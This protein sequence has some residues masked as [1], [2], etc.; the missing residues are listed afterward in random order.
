M[1]ESD[2]VLVFS[3]N[4]D[5]RSIYDS[6]GR[7]ENYMVQF[8]EKDTSSFNI[9]MLQ[10]FKVIII[11]IM[12]PSMTEIEFIETIHKFEQE[13]PILVISSYFYE[14]KDI[15][16]GDKIAGFIHKPF[17]F[18]I[19]H[20][21]VN[22]ITKK[23]KGK[24]K[25]KEKPVVHK[26]PD[27]EFK[28]LSVLFE[29]SKTIN[30]ATN[31][32]NLLQTIIKLSANAFDCERATVFILDT[33]KN[34]LWSKVGTG[35][36]KKE[37]RLKVDRGIAGEVAKTGISLMIED[38]YKHPKF[39]KDIDISTGFKTNSILCV[40]MKNLRG[41]T[42]GVF[43]LL[44][45]KDSPFIA[46]DEDFLTA[47]ATTTGVA[48]ENALLYE[49]LVKHVDAVSPSINLRNKTIGELV[50]LVECILNDLDDIDDDQADL[51]MEELKRRIDKVYKD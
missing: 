37:I 11:E 22:S 8:A 5:T 16:F 12:Y 28:K 27:Y 43:Q 4:R 13:T 42:L 14:T 50:D 29:I 30:T 25:E 26:D 20:K 49:K 51:I 47:I 3:N 6:F 48:L 38:A 35:L 15:L 45:K 40:P 19:L 34:E 33:E 17:T 21:E 46:E 31:L 9:M 18:E 24:E 2:H 36:D 7:T 1:K 39:V 10:K 23:E 41:E 32:D 44:N